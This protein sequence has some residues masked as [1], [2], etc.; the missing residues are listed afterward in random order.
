MGVSEAL[1]SVASAVSTSVGNSVIGYADRAA[2][3]RRLRR[4]RL[5]DLL[6][7]LLASR[8]SSIAYEESHAGVVGALRSQAVKSDVPGGL[9]LVHF[10]K[11]RPGETKGA[12][13][14]PQWFLA[15][16]APA[17]CDVAEGEKGGVALYLVFRGTWST[18]DIIRDMCVEPEDHVAAGIERRFHGGFLRGVRDD[19]ELHTQLRRALLHSPGGRKVEHL[20]IFGHSLGG[21]LALVLTSAGFLPEEYDGKVTVVGVGSPPVCQGEA[22]AA[23]AMRKMRKMQPLRYPPEADDEEA[24]EKAAAK[25]KSDADADA[26]AEAEAAK[27]AAQAASMAAVRY[28]LVVNECDVVP[29]LLG[30]PMPVSTAAMLATSA[31]GL[32]GTQTVM[33]RNVELMETMQGYSHPHSIQTILLRH[34]SAK[35][36]PPAERHAVLHLH[37]ALSPHL[38]DHHASELYVKALEI[39]AALAEA[40]EGD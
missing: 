1:K 13:I 6:L 38:L 26:E 24:S 9:Q 37:E 8:L 2:R 29:R 39:S 27:A 7:A 35:A 10:R 34:G 17:A 18:N 12:D 22:A 21:S 28:L 4:A 3:Q 30:S 33:R 32:W 16:G 14:H 23:A 36:V 40:Y 25:A 19:P 11:Q 20:Y 5:S 31:Q 15:R